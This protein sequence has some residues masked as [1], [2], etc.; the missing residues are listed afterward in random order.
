MPFDDEIPLGGMIE[1]P[2]AALDA[3][4]FARHL[5]FLS[6]GTNDLIQYTL[7]V[8]R[9]DEDVNHLYKPAHPA[10]LKL[11][12]M[13]IKAGIK[14]GIPVTMCGEMAGDIRYVRLL[15]GMGLRVFSMNPRSCLDVRRIVVNSSVSELSALMHS[16]HRAG[17]SSEVEEL[18]DRINQ[19]IQ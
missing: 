18:L 8:D 14:A 13:T 4:A 3:D 5:D 9:L 12:R 7:A 10:V 1:V 11:I 17:T 16:V 6:I 2:A 19:D 15:L